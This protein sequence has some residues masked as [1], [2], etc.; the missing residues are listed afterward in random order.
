MMNL[1]TQQTMIGK[2]FYSRTP[3]YNIKTGC[4]DFKNRPVLIIGIADIGDLNVLPLSRVTNRSNL[5]AYY[6]ISVQKDEYPLLGLKADSYI[7]THKLMFINEAELSQ[8]YI[9]DIK[10]N[11]PD[12]FLE[13]LSR[14][15]DYNKKLIM[16]AI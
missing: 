15:E 3:F 11:Y 14:L 9:G 10:G 6:D 5:D 7:R 12:L 2:I 4:Q 1:K 13:V 8:P 16:S